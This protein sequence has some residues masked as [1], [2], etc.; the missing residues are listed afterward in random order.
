MRSA[1]NFGE[2]MD[3]F[4][5]FGSA[6][7]DED[8]KMDLRNNAVGIQIFKKAGINATLEE[9][10]EAVDAKVLEQLE[11]IMGRSPEER[12]TPA[13]DQPNAPANFKSPEEGFDVYFN[14]DKDG[15]FDTTRGNYQQFLD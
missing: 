8:M 2:F 10:A 6:S 12:M 15:Y 13:E 1:G 4:T 11:V 5:P 14:R 9:L 7:N 3:R